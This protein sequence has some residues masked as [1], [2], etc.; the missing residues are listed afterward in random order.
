MASLTER[1]ALHDGNT[2]PL[3]G[4]GCWAM[5]E[6]TTYNAV[7]TA[8]NK[9]YKLIDTAH[10]Y[11]NEHSVGKA[12]KDSGLSRDDFFLVTKLDYQRHGT[13]GVKQ[14]L[15]ESLE[16]LGLDYVD[17]ILIHTPMS[18]KVLETWKAL[19]ELKKEGKAKSIG[20]SNFNG[21]H[22]QAL[23]DAG[24]EKPAVNQFEIHPTNRQVF[25]ICLS[26][27]LFFFILDSF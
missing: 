24:L 22:I 4:L 8:L 3:F 18:G 26:F 9:G 20:V 16:K 21:D 27:T 2:I 1:I 5:D 13:E 12:I 25:K 14:S 19:M 6:E 15:K 10:G 23:L 17:L 7:Q 11:K